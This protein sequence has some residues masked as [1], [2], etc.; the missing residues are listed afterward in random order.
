MIDAIYQY[1]HSLSQAVGFP[2]ALADDLLGVFVI[3]VAVVGKGRE[4]HQTFDEQIGQLHK[5]SEFG[6]ADY[7]TVEF[8]TNSTLHELDLLPFHQLTLSIVGAAFGLAGLFSDLVHHLKRNWA[9]SLG[10][11]IDGRFILM[12]GA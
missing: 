5:H 7:E 6:H 2:G 3:S 9:F 4:W 8:L 11:R 10:T 12:P 1:S